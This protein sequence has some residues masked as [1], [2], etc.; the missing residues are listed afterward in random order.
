LLLSNGNLASSS[1]DKTIRIWNLNTGKLIKILS[2]HTNRVVSIVA[3]DNAHLASASWDQ[4]I[5][6]WNIYNGVNLKSYRC[7][8][9]FIYRK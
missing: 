9:K 2:G 4:T 6:I 5:R 1:A 7:H 3:L 8:S